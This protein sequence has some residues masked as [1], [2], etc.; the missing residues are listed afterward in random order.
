MTHPLGKPPS[1]ALSP[2]N[3]VGNCWSFSGSTGT[4]GIEFEGRVWLSHLALYHVP[5]GYSRDIGAA[6][7]NVTLWGLTDA[8]EWES[9]STPIAA[10]PSAAASPERRRNRQLLGSFRYDAYGRNRTQEFVLSIQSRH[11]QFSVEFTSNWGHPN[12]TCIYQISFRGWQDS[13]EGV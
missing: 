2:D 6:P 3:F 10:A 8:D 4:L 13:V 7:Q 1:V 5:Q 9:P 12:F 11:E